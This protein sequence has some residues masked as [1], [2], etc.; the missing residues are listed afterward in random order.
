VPGTRVEDH[1]GVGAEDEG[2]HLVGVGGFGEVEPGG[3]DR[4][5]GIGVEGHE[6]L[7]VGAVPEQDIALETSFDRRDF[8]DV[9]ADQI[10]VHVVPFEAQPMGS[11]AAVGV[12]HGN[13]AEGGPSGLG[14]RCGPNPTGCFPQSPLLV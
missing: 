4:D 1:G 2:L 12:G 5:D 6:H 14:E 13:P 3:G 8:G 10:D 11:V 7:G 9:V